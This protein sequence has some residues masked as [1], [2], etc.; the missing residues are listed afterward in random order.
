[1][2]L[3]LCILLVLSFL[4]PFTASAQHWTADEQEVLTYIEK[5]FDDK[6]PAVIAVGPFLYFVGHYI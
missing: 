3:L 6:G 2:R 5:C 1:M 4:F